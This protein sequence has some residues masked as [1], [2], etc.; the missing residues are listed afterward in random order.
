MFRPRHLALIA[1]LLSV[2]ASAAAS[3]ELRDKLQSLAANILK[4]TRNQPVTVGVFSGTGLPETNSGPGIEG[5]LRNA[6]NQLLAG[7]VKDDATF[8]VKGDYAFAKSTDP[9]NAGL[10]VAKIKARLID[11]ETG[12]E[13]LGLNVSLD[14]QLDGTRTIAELIQ[15]SASLPPD[16]TKAE[17]NRRLDEAR[18]TPTVEC[19]GSL[20][21]SS[22]G[23]LY[24]VELIAGPPSSNDRDLQPRSARV[25]NGQAFVNVAEGEV[26]ALRIHNKDA[27]PIAVAISVDGL[28][29]YHFSK[30]RDPKTG[31]PLYTHS[32][33]QPGESGVILGWHH[34]VH[35]TPNYH[36]FQIKKYGEGESSKAGIARGKT[37]VVQVSIGYCEFLAE[38]Q[39]SR[40]GFETGIGPPVNVAQTP[41]RAELK[42]PHDFVAIRYSR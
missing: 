10:K 6:L 32:I 8:E 35:G 22:S 20:V 19:H 21:S 11:K 34:Q 2:D 9:K 18:K 28:D 12:E 4:A 37:G 14:L 30:D 26:Y 17:R 13:V 27:K 16:G 33:L 3:N 42:P 7:C 31:H 24:Q 41:V 38:G 40:S 1:A 15:V 5:E 39:R 36:R 25:E 29:M 23:S